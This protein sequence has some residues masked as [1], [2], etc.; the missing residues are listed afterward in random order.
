MPPRHQDDRVFRARRDGPGFR[1][2]ESGPEPREY[3][4]DTLDELARH[5]VEFFT[6]R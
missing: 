2:E 5:V 4:L 6:S 3:A 1:V